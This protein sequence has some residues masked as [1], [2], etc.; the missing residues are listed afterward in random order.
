MLLVLS[1]LIQL[2]QPYRSILSHRFL[3]AAM[4]KTERMDQSPPDAAL[5]PSSHNQ[6][7]WERMNTH[8]K[9]GRARQSL[10]STSFIKFI[11]DIKVHG[12]FFSC[13]PELVV[14]LSTS[15]LQFFRG[16]GNKLGRNGVYHY[17]LSCVKTN[18]EAWL[19]L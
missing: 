4:L 17:I 7:G 15:S 12:H 13:F 2:M 5:Q 3:P 6:D 8:T 18:H 9:L 19:L 14:R 1:A 11:N 10:I 16:M